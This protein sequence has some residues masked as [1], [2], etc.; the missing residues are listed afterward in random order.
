[1][2]VPQLPPLDVVLKH[3]VRTGKVVIGSR[4]T[5]KYVKLGRVKAVVAASNLPRDLKEDLEYYASLSGIP[6]IVFPG[7]N[8][9][10]GT[11]IGKPFSVAMM[12]ILDPGQVPMELLLLYAKK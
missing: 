10:L 11:A 4:K 5:L 9:D 3:V 1:M 8:Y 12:G 2:S 6:I 7:T